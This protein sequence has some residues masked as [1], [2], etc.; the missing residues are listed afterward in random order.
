MEGFQLQMYHSLFK[1]K[2]SELSIECISPKARQILF[3]KNWKAVINFPIFFPTI[4]YKI[5]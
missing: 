4:I 2:E 5:I 3:G 1:T